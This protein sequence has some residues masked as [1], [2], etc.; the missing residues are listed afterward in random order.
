MYSLNLRWYSRSSFNL[1][2]STEHLQAHNPQAKKATDKQVKVSFLAS[3]ACAAVIFCLV[4]FL[5][6]AP[7]KANVVIKQAN[8]MFRTMAFITLI[9]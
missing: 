5:P 1:R 2:L 8:N 7:K 9:Y 4:C 6:T 3:A